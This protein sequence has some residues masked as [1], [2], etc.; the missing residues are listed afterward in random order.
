MKLTR[1]TR[2]A[3]TEPQLE[4]ARQLWGTDLSVQQVDE[5]LPNDSR[6]AVARFDEIAADSDIVE[7]VLPLNL[8][9]AILK[10]S[11]FAKR[12]GLL[13]RSVMNRSGEGEAVVFQF[14]H[15]ERVLKVSIETERL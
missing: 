15:F 2:H 13:V 6:A 14:S 5:S 9:E 12:G 1:L 10:F 7:A 11:G 8:V 3:A 4:A